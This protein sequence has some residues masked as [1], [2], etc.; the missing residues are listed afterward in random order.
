L[1]LFQISGEQAAPARRSVRPRKRRLERWLRWP[2]LTIDLSRSKHRRNLL[3]ALGALSLV[4]IASLAGGYQA[5]MFSESSE[6]CGTICHPMAS[7]FVRYE[8][9]P[10]AHVECTKCHIG[11]GLGAFVK[12]KIEGVSELVAVLSDSYE[13]PIT[14]PVHDLR[15]A[16]ETCEECH[17]PTFFTDNIIKTI[18]HYA[19]IPNMIGFK[20]VRNQGSPQLGVDAHFRSRGTLAPA[21]PSAGVARSRSGGENSRP[22]RGFGNPLGARRARNTLQ[23]DCRNRFS[24]QMTL[25]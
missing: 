12:A 23:G 15:P 13:R 11:P 10:H 5:F 8:Q 24:P 7:E 3:L 25:N 14:S 6:F 9:S 18:T 1:R 4:G 16:R 2:N 17:A 19:A 22:G 21:L 20:K